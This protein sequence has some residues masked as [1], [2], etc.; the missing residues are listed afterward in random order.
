MRSKTRCVFCVSGPAQIGQAQVKRS[1]ARWLPVTPLDSAELSS[2]HNLGVVRKQVPLAISAQETTSDPTVSTA[3]TPPRAV[4]QLHTDVSVQ[5]RGARSRSQWRSTERASLHVAWR[6]QEEK[7]QWEAGEGHAGLVRGRNGPRAPLGV[8]RWGLRGSALACKSFLLQ[9]RSPSSPKEL[10]WKN[11]PG[12][13]RK[14]CL[15]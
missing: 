14:T 11:I 7:R 1:R 3:T 6:G 4:S 9:K 8:G 12:R 10:S 2:R 15:S 5:T 13:E